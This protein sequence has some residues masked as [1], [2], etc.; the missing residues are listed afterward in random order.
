M[1]LWT[2]RQVVALLIF[3]LLAL[4]I[5]TRPAGSPSALWAGRIFP[6]VVLVI[7]ALALIAVLRKR[8]R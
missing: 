5:L 2:W 7:A 4:V 1:F 3:L 8:D 6:G